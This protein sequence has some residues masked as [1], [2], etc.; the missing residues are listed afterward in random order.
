MGYLRKIQGEFVAKTSYTF[1]LDC[2]FDELMVGKHVPSLQRNLWEKIL[3]DRQNRAISEDLLHRL[4]QFHPVERD[5][6]CLY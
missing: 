1:R 2:C 5:A 3:L 4:L 6:E